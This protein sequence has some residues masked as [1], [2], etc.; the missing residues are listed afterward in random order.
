MDITYQSVALI[1]KRLKDNEGQAAVDAVELHGV[2]KDMESVDALIH[3][4][5]DRVRKEF[6][7]W[8]ILTY[9]DNRA[10]INEKKGADKGRVVRVVETNE[11]G[12]APPPLPPSAYA[13][14]SMTA[15][16]M[17][18]AK[19]TITTP[20]EAGSLN[21]RSQVVLTVEIEIKR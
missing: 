17:T 6:E 21:V 8:T 10:V 11:G 15:N 1:L 3:K 20:V 13:S 9:S 16:A 18:M 4:K 7:K 12:I 5:D 19:Q 2:P 14:S